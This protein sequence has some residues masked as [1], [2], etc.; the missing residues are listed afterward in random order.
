M[1]TKRFGLIG[2]AVVAVMLFTVLA[3]SSSDDD[4]TDTAAPAPA[5]APAPVPAPAPAAAPAQE[6][7]KDDDKMAMDFA[8]TFKGSW[9][10]DGEHPT[11]FSEAPV[12]AA[13]VASGELPPVEERLPNA[14]D[15]MVVPVVDRIGDYGGTWRRAFTGRTTVRTPTA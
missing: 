10:W 13:R 3:C 12:L 8:G 11:D 7:A 9:V 5:P 4:D 6:P 14:A 1:I 2:F 15:V